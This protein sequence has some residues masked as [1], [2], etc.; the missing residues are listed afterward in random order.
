MRRRI[1]LASLITLGV[2]SASAQAPVVRATECSIDTLHAA[3]PVRWLGTHVGGIAI[4]SRNVDMP[5]AFLSRGVQYLH[6]PTGDDVI[7][8]EF[9]VSSGD[10]VDSLLV[11]QAVRRLL[12]SQIFSEVLLEGRR[13]SDAEQ[14][15]FTLWTRD[16]WS[17]RAGVKLGSVGSR[18]LSLAELNLLG[19][20]RTVSLS[21]EAVESRHSFALGFSDPSLFGT[22]LRGSVM[23]H[24]YPD[25]TAWHWGLQTR[26]RSPYD[27][28]RLSVL[29]S[30]L[31]MVSNDI[32]SSTFIDIERRRHALT[33][34]RRVATTS[35]AVWAV[36]AG[37]ESENANLT[38]RRPGPSIARPELH[39]EFT[40][41]ILGIALRSTVFKTVDWFVERQSPAEVPV[42]ID[43]EVVVSLAH[44]NFS[45]ARLAHVDGWIGGTAMLDASTIVTGDVWSSGYWNVDSVSNGTLRLAG[46]FYRRTTNGMWIVRLASE[47]IYNPD[48][49][50]FALSTTD[51]MLRSLAS[52]AGRLAESG[53][54][55][56]IERAFHLYEYEGRWGMDGALFASFSERHGNIDPKADDPHNLY[57]AIIGV[58]LRRVGSQLTQSP[59]RIDLGR[60]IS[61]SPLLHDRWIVVFST[62]PWINAGRKRDGVREAM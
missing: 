61:R 43:G 8:A 2:A 48:P 12:L 16:A 1:A 14:T 59:L 15:D 34:S 58:G 57:A 10:A 52:G 37:V 49:D 50:V 27:R 25:G 56:S 42:G 29:S 35:D 23:G 22:R 3:F 40:A 54:L 30:Q 21:S 38:V 44:E 60:A 47:R 55:A 6:V 17:V 20:G 5:A 39:R 45:A 46:G 18:R 24:S 28:W 33:L 51:P 26:D 7:R 13:C 32:A 53:L 9:G 41:P 62:A 4:R 19:T 36:V 11:K 31:A